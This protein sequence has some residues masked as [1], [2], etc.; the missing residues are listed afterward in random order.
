MGSVIK[1]YFNQ[2]ENRDGLRLLKE[3]LKIAI[4]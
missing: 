4:F 2:N 1:E 3:I